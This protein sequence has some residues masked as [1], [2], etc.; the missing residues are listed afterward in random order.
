MGE[1]RVIVAAVLAVLLFMAPAARAELA[2]ADSGFVE[3]TVRDGDD[4]SSLAQI[5]RK[6]FS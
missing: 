3:D 5:D 1:L 4:D 6:G 2:L